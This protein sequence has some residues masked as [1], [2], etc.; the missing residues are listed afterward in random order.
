MVEVELVGLLEMELPIL[1]LLEV[2]VVVKVSTMVLMGDELTGIHIG[3]L[4]GFAL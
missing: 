1:V 2:V 4:M 3:H